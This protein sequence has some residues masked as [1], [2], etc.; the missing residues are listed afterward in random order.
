VREINRRGVRNARE[1]REI[2]G[3][4]VFIAGSIGPVDQ[5]IQPFGTLSL[6]DV[7]SILL[8]PEA[9]TTGT[10]GDLC[11]RSVPTVTPDTSL[12]S[13]LVRMEEDNREELPVVDPADPTR[14]LG[15]LSRADVIR[16]YNRALLTMRTLPG[17]A[18]ADEVPQWSKG[19]RVVRLPLPASWDGRT[20]R[21]LD[22][23]AQY[24]VTVLAVEPR[25]KPGHTFEVPDPDRR[26]EAGD[27]L[28]MAG[29]NASVGEFERTVRRWAAERKAS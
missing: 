25:D 19:H 13:A 4:T 11:D 27:T 17:T 8:D 18:G 24:G 23:R 28:V 10:A 29:P 21:E 3:E 26:L 20:L 16:A 2:S 12:G 15:L 9:G 6:R 5:P 7:R 22:C 1:A 14:V